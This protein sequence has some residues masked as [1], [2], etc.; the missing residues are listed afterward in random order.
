MRWRIYYV[1]S[2]A[3]GHRRDPENTNSPELLGRAKTSAWKFS[4]TV[5]YHGLER[6]NLGDPEEF[7]ANA[8]LLD[9]S[10][11]V[12]GPATKT[13]VLNLS[14]RAAAV[15]CS[16]FVNEDSCAKEASVGCAWNSE[17]CLSET[18]HV[19]MK[20]LDAEKD[21][22]LRAGSDFVDG[23]LPPPFRTGV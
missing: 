13:N 6:Y 5:W 18:W 4:P 19:H 1:E 11:T 7:V 12:L 16:L 23:Q 14:R 3:R 9:G 17:L 10:E 8:D 15:N 21:K 20:V 2:A 22:A